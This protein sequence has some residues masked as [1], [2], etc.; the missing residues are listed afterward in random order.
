[1]ANTIMIPNHLIIRSTFIDD[2]T[3]PDNLRIATFDAQEQYIQPVLGDLLY[4]K[5]LDGLLNGT[6]SETYQLLIINYIYPVFYQAVPIM[7]YQDLLYR[8][9]ASSIVKDDNENSKSVSKVELNTL[10]AKREQLMNYHIKRLKDYLL[11]YE[12]SFPEYLG[13]QADDGVAPDLTKNNMLF[14]NYEDE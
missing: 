3:D 13:S 11:A 1:M 10:I 5:I 14:F 6:I 12:S 2:N 8:I 9:T 4:E 7:L